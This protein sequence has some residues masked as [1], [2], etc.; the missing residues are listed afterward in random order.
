MV[1]KFA[2]L[3]K[4]DYTAGL[5]YREQR[6][7]TFDNNAGRRFVKC[8]HRVFPAPRIEEKERIHAAENGKKIMVIS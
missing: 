3:I 5:H 8:F 4:A 7:H 1:I 6:Q 2:L